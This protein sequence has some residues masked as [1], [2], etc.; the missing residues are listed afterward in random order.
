MGA[1][2]FFRFGRRLVMRLVGDRPNFS[3]ELRRDCPCLV[4]RLSVWLRADSRPAHRDFHSGSSRHGVSGLQLVGG[5]TR[6]SGLRYM[7]AKTTM[8]AADLN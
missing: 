4:P 2:V 3:L 5:T 7:T 8:C 6:L 1:P